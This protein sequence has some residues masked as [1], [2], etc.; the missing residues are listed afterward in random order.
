V[1]GRWANRPALGPVLLVAGGDLAA[2]AF[3]APLARA[4]VW[5]S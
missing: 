4:K 3:E 5:H 1:G 2:E